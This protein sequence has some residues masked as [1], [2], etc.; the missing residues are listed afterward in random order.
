MIRR[1]IGSTLAAGLCVTLL[2]GAPPKAQA[3]A[4]DNPTAITQISLERTPCFGM[5]PEYKVV[6]YADGTAR[7]EGKRHVD[8]QGRYISER[9]GKF[10]FEKLAALA[11]AIEFEKLKDAYRAPATDLPSVIVTVHYGKKI[12]QVIDYGN[13]EPI[14]LWGFEMAIDGAASKV[15]WKADS[16][17]GN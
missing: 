4:A 7:Y 13:L 2:A 17:A 9:P 1:M 3:P 8:R 12:K 15:R 10:Y 16:D 11:D 6:F 5:C 14:E